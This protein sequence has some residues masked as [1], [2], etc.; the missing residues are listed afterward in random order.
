MQ[1]GDFVSGGNRYL[2]GGVVVK[3]HDFMQNADREDY[4]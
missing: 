1:S 4:S 3:Y 2:T